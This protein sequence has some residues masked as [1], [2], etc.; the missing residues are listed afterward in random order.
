MSSRSGGPLDITGP[1]MSFTATW[2]TP[3]GGEGNGLTTRS[4]LPVSTKII[5]TDP[6][7]IPLGSIVEIQYPDGHTEIRIAADTGGAI[8]GNIIDV[9]TWSESTAIHNGRQHVKLRVI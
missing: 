5:A 8:H 2:Y 7:I 6:S 3:S 1:W 9:F 4:G